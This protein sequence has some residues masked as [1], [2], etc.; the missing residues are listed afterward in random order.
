[1]RREFLAQHP[2]EKVPF[3]AGG[4]FMHRYAVMFAKPDHDHLPFPSQV[5]RR[6]TPA[7]TT[8]IANAGDAAPIRF[9]VEVFQ[10]TH[11]NASC[12]SH[13]G[14]RAVRRGELIADKPPMRMLQTSGLALLPQ[15][16][17]VDNL[18]VCQI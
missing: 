15:P 4:E 3:G 18:L 10:H 9:E 6:A 14:G 13:I 7:R 11:Q 8:G 17:R 2:L 1:M 12:G 16:E 5:A